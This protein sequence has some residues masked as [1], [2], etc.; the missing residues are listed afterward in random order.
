MARTTL[1]PLE[2]WHF[3]KAL[4]P[5]KQWAVYRIEDDRFTKRKTKV[6]YYTDGHQLLKSKSNDSSTW[7]TLGDAL[8]LKNRNPHLAGIAFCIT[9]GFVGIDFDKVREVETNKI[10]DWVLEWVAQFHTYGEVSQS[11]TGLHFIAQ[12]HLPPQGR[13][14]EQK[15]TEIYGDRRFFV[16]TGMRLTRCPDDV[17]PM[18]EQIDQFHAFLFP[19]QPKLPLEQC[20]H[21]PISIPQDGQSVL[22][23]MFSWKNGALLQQIYTS[24]EAWQG[25]YA[26]QSSA[27]FA[28]VCALMRATNQDVGLVDSLF[29]N[30]A[31]MR[32][33]WNKR[34][35]ADGR[36]YGQVTIDNALRKT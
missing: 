29:R 35:M 3:P 26:S 20:I 18:Q 31:L 24:P 27:D 10:E 33:K 21:S 9:P 11:K 1:Q 32:E 2:P 19:P 22:E 4:R 36:T 16:F 12:G 23:R 25:Y 13:K 14:N 34:T 30:S 8:N 7:M 15:K 6:M 5:L 17:L 28:L